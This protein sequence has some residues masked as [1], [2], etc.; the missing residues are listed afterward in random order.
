MIWVCSVGKGA[1]KHMYASKT[2]KLYFFL[3]KSIFFYSILAT[4]PRKAHLIWHDL[5]SFYSVSFQMTC[6]MI[7]S[8]QYNDISNYTYHI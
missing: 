5:K 1:K 8:A 6:Y 2:L 3:K 7:L 4:E